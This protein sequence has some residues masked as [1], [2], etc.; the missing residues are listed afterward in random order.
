MKI[1]FNLKL[2]GT[3]LFLPLM[4][5]ACGGGGSSSNTDDVTEAVTIADI[6][7]WIINISD[8][9]TNIFESSV[10]SEGVLEDV[11]LAEE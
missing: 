8:R 7:N 9:S 6:S 10:S 1:L 5:S 11:Q 2:I 4:L 3:L